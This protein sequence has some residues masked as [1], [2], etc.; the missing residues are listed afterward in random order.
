MDVMVDIETTGV[1][2]EKNGILQIGAVI[3]DLNT[4]YIEPFEESFSRNV[5][6]PGHLCWDLSTYNWWQTKNK[7]NFYRVMQNTVPLWQVLVEMGEKFGSPCTRFWAKG[8]HFDFAFIEASY[9]DANLSSPFNYWLVRDM[10]TYITT[11]LGEDHE[12]DLGTYIKNAHD[13]RMD[14][15]QQI[16]EMMKAKEIANV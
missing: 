8:P 14:C 13:A 4:G 16:G 11:L 15:Y 12:Y 2:P 7:D 5:D 3:F 10:R 6:M 9:K 1:R